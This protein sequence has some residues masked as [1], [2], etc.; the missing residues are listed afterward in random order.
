MAEQLAQIEG[1]LIVH[2]TDKA[3]HFD[4]GLKKFLVPVSHVRSMEPEG[5]GEA[6]TVTMTEWIA[7]QKGLV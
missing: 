2:Q 6:Y 7:I 4:N 1:L 5:V 3:Y